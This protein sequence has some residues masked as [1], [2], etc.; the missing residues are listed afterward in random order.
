M[1]GKTSEIQ[2]DGKTIFRELPKAVYGDAVSLVDCGAR[3]RC[4]AE[5]EISAET[6]DDTIMGLRHKQH[7]VE[8][9]QF[10]PESVLMTSGFVS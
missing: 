8:G 3:D 7:Q 9:V 10:H 6:E 4:R 1:H 5:L 2:H